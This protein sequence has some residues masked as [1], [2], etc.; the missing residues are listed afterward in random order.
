MFNKLFIPGD[1]LSL[2]ETLIHD[3][4]C[5]KF[6]FIIVT[7]KAWYGIKIYVV[8]DLETSF[9]L[10]VIFNTSKYNDANYDNTDMLKTVRVVCELCKTFGG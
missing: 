2:D 3:C 9:V 4:F 6:K 7:K 5:E 10:N 8:T 1:N